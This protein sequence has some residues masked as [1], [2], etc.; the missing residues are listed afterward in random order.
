MQRCFQSS[1][2]EASLRLSTRRSAFSLNSS[3][4]DRNTQIS[5]S[6]SCSCLPTKSTARFHRIDMFCTSVK[7]TLVDIAQHA[8]QTLQTDLPDTRKM[9]PLF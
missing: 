2:A 9:S 3:L 5:S 6:T 4:F 7:Q 1:S 8:K